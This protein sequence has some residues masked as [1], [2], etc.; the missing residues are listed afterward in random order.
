MSSACLH[1]GIKVANKLLPIAK[2]TA[3]TWESI[4][5]PCARKGLGERSV[6]ISKVKMG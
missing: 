5:W 4:L 3:L 1:G 6:W 2:S